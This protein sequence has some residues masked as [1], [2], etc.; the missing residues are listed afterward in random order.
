MDHTL[1]YTKELAHYGGHLARFGWADCAR[2]CSRPVRR[3]RDAPRGCR[4]RSTSQWVDGGVALPLT[5]HAGWS[6][7]LP[8]KFSKLMMVRGFW[9]H[10]VIRQR[11]VDRGTRA[12]RLTTQ[13]AR[14][15]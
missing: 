7:T 5:R 3:R 14:R 2:N 15:P 12:G 8:T 4:P 1:E 9:L 11:P 13:D 6:G 10:A